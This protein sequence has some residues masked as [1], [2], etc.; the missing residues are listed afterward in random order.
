MSIITAI[1]L[2]S[3]LFIPGAVALDAFEAV[4]S[5]GPSEPAEVEEF[6]EALSEKSVI[7]QNS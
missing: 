2:F 4:P 6:F 7:F 5:N 1:L 3:A